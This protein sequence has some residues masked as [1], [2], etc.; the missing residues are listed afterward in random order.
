MIPAILLSRIAIAAFLLSIASAANAV[1]F[2][3]TNTGNSGPGSLFEAI[4]NLNGSA[5]GGTI[6]FDLPGSGP[7][8]ID[9]T[10]QLPFFN[11]DIQI[12]ND[13]PGDEP[14]TVRRSS[15]A[16][17]PRFGIFAINPGHTV[18]IA[19]LTIGNGFNQSSEGGGV[20]NNRSTVT[21][22]NCTISGNQGFSGGG[23]SNNTMFGSGT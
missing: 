3:I 12:V 7:H 1:T 4:T 17:T 23:I 22:R 18:L 2:T 6:I 5:A 15:V 19:G 11:K 14:V 8:V 13:G 16:G 21:V 10:S 9:L 20:S